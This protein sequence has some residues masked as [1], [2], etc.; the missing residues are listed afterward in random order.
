[1]LDQ[2]C[3][4]ALENLRT[5][6]VEPF[7]NELCQKLIRYAKFDYTRTMNKLI[8]I[9]HMMKSS[10]KMLYKK[11]S[12]PESYRL[13]EPSVALSLSSGGSSGAYRF[14]LPAVVNNNKET[15]QQGKMETWLTEASY[16]ERVQRIK[17]H[18]L[19]VQPEVVNTMIKIKKICEDLEK[20][21][22]FYDN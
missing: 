9:N 7:S 5:S 4:N 12:V 1:M 18:T 21:C 6:K 8:F 17:L 3:Y 14:N 19:Y 10:N 2:I 22:I 15:K 11:V 16:L 13:F 20:N